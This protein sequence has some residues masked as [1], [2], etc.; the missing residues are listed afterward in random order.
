VAP[1]SLELDLARLPAGQL[2]I[3][4]ELAAPQLEPAM[5]ASLKPCGD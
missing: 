5:V 1:G 3:G 2:G 4:P